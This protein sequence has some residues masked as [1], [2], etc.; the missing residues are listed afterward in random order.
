VTFETLASLLLPA[1]RAVDGVTIEADE[2]WTVQP[3]KAQATRVV[4]GRT[5][6]PSGVSVPTLLRTAVLREIAIRR[7]RRR[8]VAGLSLTAVHRW[9]PPALVPGSARNALRAALLGGALLELDGDHPTE[10]V[11][12]QVARAA[13]VKTPVRHVLPGSGGAARIPVRL[14]DGKPA[15]LRVG[16]ADGP[17]DPAWAARALRRLAFHEVP[18]APRL[19]GQGLTAGAAWSMETELPGGRAGRLTI[20]LMAQVAAFCAGLP[21]AAGAA[22]GYAGNLQLIASR[23]PWWVPIFEPLA[24]RMRQVLSQ[25][26]SITQHGDLWSGNLLVRSGR[27]TGVVDWDAWHPAGVPGADL[28]HLVA[29]EESH[30][31]RQDL[32][33]V[34]IRHPW[35]WP[36]FHA[37]AGEYW[38]RLGI[39]PD[40]GLLQAAGVA[41]WAGQIAHAFT[42]NPHLARDARWVQANVVMVVDRLPELSW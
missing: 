10:R 1:D 5:P 2:R 16:L 12:D 37:V 14:A 22:F 40:A 20:S 13:G 24:G 7:A 18:A 35:E 4:W 23:F 21:K 3:P 36:A 39:E 27:L 6:L 19:L 33:A 29:T 15:V 31:A 25:R 28:L 34:W 32:G 30:R 42:V 8:K 17:G 38:S 9:P 41:W 11:V 26:P